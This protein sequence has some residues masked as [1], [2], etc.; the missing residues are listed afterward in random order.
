MSDEVA[1]V[2]EMLKSKLGI[3]SGTEPQPEKD[4]KA[5]SCRSSRQDQ[6]NGPLQRFL[7]Y[8]YGYPDGHDVDSRDKPV[9]RRTTTFIGVK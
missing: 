6:E 5:M 8:G 7:G 1:E 3:V 4:D 9:R 2:D